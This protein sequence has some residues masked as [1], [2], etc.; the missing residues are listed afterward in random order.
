MKL[1][2]KRRLNFGNTVGVIGGTDSNGRRDLV[3][4]LRLLIFC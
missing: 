4:F 1:K 2:Q 3:D